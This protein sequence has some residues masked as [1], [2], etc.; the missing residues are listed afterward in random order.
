LCAAAAAQ[1][2]AAVARGAAQAAAR[3]ATSPAEAAQQALQAAQKAGLAK[4]PKRGTSN[5]WGMST[6][7]RGPFL[8]TLT[9]LKTN[10]CLPKKG[11]ICVQKLSSEPTINFPGGI[12]IFNGVLGG[13]SQNNKVKNQWLVV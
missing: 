1:R 5:T 6:Q 3:G 4:V 8:K 12:F 13:S 7:K 9:A 2:A 10:K 11:A